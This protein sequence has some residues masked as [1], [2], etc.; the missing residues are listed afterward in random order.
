[1]NN[2][3]WLIGLLFFCYFQLSSQ[4][5]KG[6]YVN[7]F[8]IIL[9]NTIKEDS[10]LV[11]AHNNGFNYLT[12]YDMHLVNNSTPLTNYSSAQI[13]AN[14]VN[15]AKTQYGISEIGVAAEN[16]WFFTNVIGV[17]NQQHPSPNNKVDVYNLEFEF[18]I[19]TSVSSGSYYCTSY[20]QPD[21]YSCDTS[22]AFSYYKKMLKSVDSLANLTGQKS[23]AYFGFFTPGQAQE[24]VQ[25]GVDRVLLSIYLPSVNYSQSYQY[26]YVKPR[27]EF[28]STALTNIKVLTLYSAEPSYMQTWVNSNP[29]FQPYSDLAVSLNSENGSW[30]NYIQQ[31][32]IQWFA[33]SYLPKI[34]MNVNIEENEFKFLSIYPNPANE[35]IN[36]EV[37]EKD[38]NSNLKI[39]NILG[40][41]NYSQKL[42]MISTRIAINSFL[43]GV[44][45]I[46]IESENG[47]T[48]KKIII[49]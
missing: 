22:G 43:S 28:L 34:N 41:T 14:F 36:V 45:F 47:I 5:I 16:L 27:L 31:E 33:Y 23:E 15:K 25:T 12:L 18:W 30:K 48:T 42:K 17:Y 29:F 40:Q 37:F 38:I 8:N 21:G 4:N 32:G 35:Y 44:Y 19:P 3:A 10:L 39:V 9:G 11:F 2:K 24:I 1:M 49:N 7:G 13:F 6:L 46:S 20:L 26:N